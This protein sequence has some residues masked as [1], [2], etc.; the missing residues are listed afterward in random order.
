MEELY[1][2]SE[3]F[4]GRIIELDW[5]DPKGHKN[6]SWRCMVVSVPAPG[7]EQTSTPPV[8]E[9]PSQPNQKSGP[10]LQEQAGATSQEQALEQADEL[11]GE[12]ST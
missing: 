4:P 8:E 12:F 10:L 11:S 3:L 5:P 1:N 7:C 2:R 6:V 9:Q